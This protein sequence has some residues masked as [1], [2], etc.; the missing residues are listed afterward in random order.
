MDQP[1]TKRTGRRRRIAAWFVAIVATLLVCGELYTRFWLGWCDMPLYM[2]DSRIEYLLLPNQD[3]FVQRHRILINS[4]SMRS[5]PLSA[6]KSEPGEGRVLMVGDSVINGG[7]HIDQSELI[8]TLLEERLPADLQRPVS[9]GNVSCASWGP[10]N[11]LEYFRKSGFFEADVIVIVMPAGDASDIPTF[12]DRVGR[13]AWP[14]RKPLLGLWAG[15]VRAYGRL[16]R[17]EDEDRPALRDA[18]RVPTQEEVDAAMSALTELVL[19]AREAGAK[20]V[21]AQHLMEREI[22]GNK[23]AGHA[24]IEA[25]A[26]AHDVPLVALGPAFAEAIAAGIDPY[27]DWVHPN[28]AGY[29]VMADVLLPVLREMLEE[30]EGQNEE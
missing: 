25:V 8:S 10:P 23:A 6:R 22:S 5:G 12:D 11:Y 18:D 19:L 16:T 1:P 9:V 20:V 15:L 7:I 2:T 17:T 14:D 30:S 13:P 29:R 28:A 24:H 27:R 4:F 21:I 3:C 26:R